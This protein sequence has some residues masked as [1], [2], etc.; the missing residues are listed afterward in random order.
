[1]ENDADRPLGA[2]ILV[3]SWDAALT[4]RLLDIQND[5]GLDLRT[6]LDMAGEGVCGSSCDGL[7]VGE[8][9]GPALATSRRLG[10]STFPR[11]VMWGARAKPK[12]TS[13]LGTRHLARLDKYSSRP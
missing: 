6:A 13:Y 10:P 3:T 9:P 8:R 12:A 11:H 7:G 2:Q 1:M 5:K 4:F